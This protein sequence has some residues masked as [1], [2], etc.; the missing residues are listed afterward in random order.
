MTEDL[1]GDNLIGD[2][3]KAM[4]EANAMGHAQ[5]FKQLYV[6]ISLQPKLAEFL[7]SAEKTEHS[8]L[9]SPVYF[10]DSMPEGQF[11]LTSSPLLKIR[12]ALRMASYAV[13]NMAFPARQMADA[14]YRLGYV[15][16]EYYSEGFLDKVGLEVEEQYVI[17]PWML[18]IILLGVLVALTI[19]FS[20]M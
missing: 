14:M 16:S 10:S 3:L 5:S 13:A 18:Y 15:I 4:Q 9:G 7:D 12:P 6:P 1:E 20:G 2:L 19:F 11:I 8:I 17:T